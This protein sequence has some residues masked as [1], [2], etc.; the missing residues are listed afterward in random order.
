L[1]PEGKVPHATITVFL[2]HHGGEVAACCPQSETLLLS[3][4]EAALKPEGKV[5]HAT[6]TVFLT[7]HGSMVIACWPQS[8][9]LLSFSAVMLL[10]L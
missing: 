1:K 6:M 9:T 8:E 10:V 7:R 5:P 4:E 3:Q 2:T